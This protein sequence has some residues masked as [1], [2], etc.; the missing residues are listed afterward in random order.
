MTEITDISSSKS[1][2][3]VVIVNLPPPRWESHFKSD[4]QESVSPTV[5]N[6]NFNN[7]LKK[8]NPYH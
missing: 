6:L 8:F 4:D 7:L 1:S 2:M 5:Q 3:G